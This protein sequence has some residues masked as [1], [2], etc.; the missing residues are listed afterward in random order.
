M[1]AFI[2]LLIKRFSFLLFV[3][4]LQSLFDFDLLF[5]LLLSHCED[6][7]VWVD[8]ILQMPLFLNIYE[9]IF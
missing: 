7:V 8:P 4:V 5:D 2:R 6:S 9:L 1:E 3:T